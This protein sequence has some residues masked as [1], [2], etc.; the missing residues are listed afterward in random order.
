MRNPIFD[1]VQKFGVNIFIDNQSVA[2][3]T[4]TG[5]PTKGDR[6]FKTENDSRNVWPRKS[7][8]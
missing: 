6:G 4:S 2:D 5:C 7:V 8:L 3:Q 1:V